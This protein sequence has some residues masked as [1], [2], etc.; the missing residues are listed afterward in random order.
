M[1]A[2][3]KIT[4]RPFGEIRE[5]DAKDILEAAKKFHN[6]RIKNREKALCLIRYALHVG[7]NWGFKDATDLKKGK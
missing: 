4:K 6:I 2:S 7:Y 1:M 5:Y 3:K